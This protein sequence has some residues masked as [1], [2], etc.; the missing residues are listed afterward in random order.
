MII[1]NIQFILINKKDT[2]QINKMDK[3]EILGYPSDKQM[4]KVHAQK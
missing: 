4:E 1:Y 3:I 2:H